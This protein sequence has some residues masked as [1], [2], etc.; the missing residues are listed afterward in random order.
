MTQSSPVLAGRAR[1]VRR[2]VMTAAVV[3][4]LPVAASLA[5]MG[6]ASAA[7]AGPGVPGIPATPPSNC[8]PDIGAC[9]YPD[10]ETT[11]VPGT[12]V[13]QEVPEQ[14]SSGPGWSYNPAGYV[15]V[16]GSGADLTDLLIPYDV[17]ITASD[18]TLQDDEITH[19][20]ITGNVKDHDIRSTP[21]M[22]PGIY[23]AITLRHADDV[24]VLDTTISGYT[25]DS[26]TLGGGIVDVY[27]DATDL[28]VEHDNIAD[29]SIAVQ[30][31]SGTI[32]DNYIHSEMTGANASQVVGVESDGGDESLTIDGNTILVGTSRKWAVGLFSDF[33]AQGNKSIEGNV[34]GGGDYVLYCGYTSGGPDT[35]NIMVT[36][37]RFSNYFY[38]NGGYYGPVAHW[39]ANPAADGVFTNNYWDYNPLDLITEP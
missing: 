19:G 38:P 21:A 23:D 36:N 16:T 17:V 13:L 20:V 30:A 4:A 22:D 6:S 34:L 32:D 31:N 2:I 14:V 29:T 15:Q 3:A 5:A 12:V 11:G 8:V 35:S 24:S 7:V 10:A 33:G 25:A 39:D 37:N 18:V 1:R 9:G 27:G 28:S 26:A